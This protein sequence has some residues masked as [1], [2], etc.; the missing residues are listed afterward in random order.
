MTGRKTE[1]NFHHYAA[2]V[3]SSKFLQA[4]TF[5]FDF[6]RRNLHH[7]LGLNVLCDPGPLRTTE[8]WWRVD[9]EC[10][11]I[12]GWTIPLSGN[13]TVSLSN[14]HRWAHICMYL[15]WLVWHRRPIKPTQ[16]SRP[17]FVIHYLPG[18]L[19]AEQ[20]RDLV[21][22]FANR[23]NNNNNKRYHVISNKQRGKIPA[24][25][26]RRGRSHQGVLNPTSS[27][28]VDGFYHFRYS[29]HHTFFL[30]KFGFNLSF[31]AMKFSDTSWLTA[32]TDSRLAPSPDC[33]RPGWLGLI[34]A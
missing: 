28:L 23:N 32:E 5:W 24:Q 33:D 17:L 13:L 25:T 34:S 9:N 11:F 30:V 3:V 20:E 22:S 27:M 31:D 2:A 14:E 21:L 10:I 15:W 12:V 19:A 8:E 16:L 6:K 26:W 4:P 1:T 18:T 7:V 29:S